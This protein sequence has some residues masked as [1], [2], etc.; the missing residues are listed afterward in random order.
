MRSGICSISM[1]P[2]AYKSGDARRWRHN[3]RASRVNISIVNLVTMCTLRHFSTTVVE[4]PPPSPSLSSIAHWSVFCGCRPT[5][6]ILIE[7]MLF[8][9][10]FVLRHHCCSSAATSRRHCV[11]QSSYSSPQCPAV[12]QTITVTFNTV[13]CPCNGLVR[14][15]SP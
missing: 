6:L 7:Q 15:V 13:R 4:N 10:L 14:E 5:S 8:R 9:R 1:R 3:G 2:H 12:W 11:F